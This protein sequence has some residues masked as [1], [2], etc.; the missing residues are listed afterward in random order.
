LYELQQSTLGQINFSTVARVEA[1]CVLRTYLDADFY[2]RHGTAQGEA[3]LDLFIDE[4]LQIL[5]KVTAFERAMA[6]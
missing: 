4:V 3:A 5:A 6:N 2:R 1:K